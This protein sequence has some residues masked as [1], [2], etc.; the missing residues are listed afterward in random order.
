[1]QA[2]RSV[3]LQQQTSM[4]GLNGGYEGDVW[5]MWQGAF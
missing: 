1:M 3:A 4:A 2:L 5:M